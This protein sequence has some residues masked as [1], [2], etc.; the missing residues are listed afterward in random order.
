MPRASNT[1]LVP[2]GEGRAQRIIFTSNWSGATSTGKRTASWMRRVSATW[3]GI[4]LT[5]FEASEWGQ[6]YPAI[7]QSWRRAW[8]EVIPFFAFPDEVRR[9]VYTTNAIEALN[10]KLRRAVKI[11]GHFPNDDAAMKLIYL[12]LRDATA[13][14]KMSAR[15]WSEAKSQ[16]AILFEERFI[17]R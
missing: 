7:G 1:T 12:V 6:R 2:S 5:A 11:R 3:K 16:F 14:W 8:S 4:S 10:S 17:I 15:E 9:I 13:E